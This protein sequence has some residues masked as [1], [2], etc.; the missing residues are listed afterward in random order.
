MSTVSLLG[1][2]GFEGDIG[3]VVGHALEKHDKPSYKSQSI[4]SDFP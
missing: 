2:N 3:V 4:L 1:G